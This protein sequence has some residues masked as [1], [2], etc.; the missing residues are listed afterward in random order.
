MADKVDAPTGSDSGS[1]VKDTNGAGP[2][3]I[4]KNVDMSEEMQ[5]EAV[6]VA[7]AALEKYSIEKDTTAQIRTEFYKR[8]GLTGTSSSTGAFAPALLMVRPTRI[9]PHDLPRI[10]AWT[11]LRRCERD[12]ANPFP[13]HPPIHPSLAPDSYTHLCYHRRNNVCTS[14]SKRSPSSADPAH[15]A[16]SE[17]DTRLTHCNND[18]LTACS[19]LGRRYSKSTAR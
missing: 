13:P 7:S 3:A 16:A 12:Y 17:L 8:H 15:P 4:I 18:P 11:Q 2:K 14:T 9:T 1:L 19:T 6:D 5:Q 10:P